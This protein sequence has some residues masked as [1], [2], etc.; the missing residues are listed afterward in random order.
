M[1]TQLIVLVIAIIT[2]FFIIYSNITKPLTESIYIVNTYMYIFGG[3]LLI[4]LF[5]TIFDKYDLMDINDS[6]RILGVFFLSM[7]SLVMILV[8]SKDQQILKHI[9]FIMFMLSLSCMTY[10]YYKLGLENNTLWKTFGAIGAIIGLMAYIAYSQPLETFSKW[11]TYLTTTLFGLIVFEILDLIFGDY[12]SD[13]FK[14]RTKIYSWIAI[15]L[16]SGFLIYD[17]QQI[18]IHAKQIGISC[19]SKK[20]IDCADYPSESLSVILD[21]VNLFQSVSNVNN[22]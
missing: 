7:I 17:T 9:A 13:S 15:A 12:A 14:T 10:R 5:S 20:Q 21:I 11:G 22:K 3:L 2:I 19:P 18:R 4:G 16:F 6:S 8:T 1:D